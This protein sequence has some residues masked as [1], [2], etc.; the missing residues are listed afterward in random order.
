MCGIFGVITKAESSYDNQF[1]KKSLRKLAKLSETRGKDSSGL[2]TLNNSDNS[3]HV[4]KGPIP[5][6]QILTR[7]KV[8]KDINHV[9]SKENKDKLKLVFGHARLVTNGTQ[10]EDANNQ[11]VIKDD[12]IC[13]HNGIVVNVD[14][15]WSNH[16]KLN[17]EHEIDTEV[18]PALVRMDLN[19]GKSVE[20]SVVNSIEKVF[21]TASI[22]MTFADI[23]KFELLIMV[24]Y[25][26]YITIKTFF[27]LHRKKGC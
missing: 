25:I 15:L 9:F 6:N 11:P 17:R 8:K 3:F 7:S 12:I 1:L 26:F 23:Q 4:V 14:E 27:I 18:I 20:S 21:G 13:I 24:L 2:C 10:L 22:A 19:E 16:K 5:A